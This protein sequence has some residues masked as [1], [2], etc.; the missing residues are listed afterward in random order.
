MSKRLPD[1]T[2]RGR[3]IESNIQL[4]HEAERACGS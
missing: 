1:N 2:T 3:L 4:Y